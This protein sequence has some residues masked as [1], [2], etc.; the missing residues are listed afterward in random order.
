ML[1]LMRELLPRNQISQ[2]SQR[3]GPPHK[4]YLNAGGRVFVALRIDEHDQLLAQLPW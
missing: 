3:K 1:Y 4:Q 2:P